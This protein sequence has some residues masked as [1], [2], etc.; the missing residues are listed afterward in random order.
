MKYRDFHC[1][2]IGYFYCST[3][4]LVHGFQRGTFTYNGSWECFGRAVVCV[5]FHVIGFVGIFMVDRCSCYGWDGC[6]DGAKFVC[7]SWS[8]IIV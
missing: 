7:V 6:G 5:Y 3:I 2:F 4:F 1:C 8:F